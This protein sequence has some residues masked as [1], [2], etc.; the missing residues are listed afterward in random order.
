LDFEVPPVLETVRGQL[1]AREGN[2]AGFGVWRDRGVVA[3]IQATGEGA[4]GAVEIDLDD[5][6][7]RLEGGVVGLEVGGAFG[8]AQRSRSIDEELGGRLEKLGRRTCGEGGWF[9]CRDDLR[10]FE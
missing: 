6:A 3:G 1:A 10:P 9:P 5:G 7:A 4:A 8:E 2:P